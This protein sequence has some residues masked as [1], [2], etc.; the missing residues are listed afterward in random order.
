MDWQVHVTRAVCLAAEHVKPDKTHVGQTGHQL[1]PWGWPD[2]PGTQDPARWC[3]VLR[4][5]ARASA[6][7]RPAARNV[8][9]RR[10]HRVS[11]VRVFPERA[12][13]VPLIASLYVTG[14][15]SASSARVCGSLGGRVGE[16]AELN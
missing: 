3:V 12:T 2:D 16:G 14:L 7:G 8:A 10:A 15:V 9:K 4:Q 11:R 13:L 1:D 5:S 6:C